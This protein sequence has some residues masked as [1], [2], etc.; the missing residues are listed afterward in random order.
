MKKLITIILT[1]FLFDRLYSQ[2]SPHDEEIMQIKG[3]W[4]RH[5]DVN[6]R[7]DSLSTRNQSGFAIKKIDSIA[8]LLK[9]ACPD[10]AGIEASWYGSIN[11]EPIF[12][13]APASYSLMSLYKS[14]YF[15]NNFNKILLG[16]ETGTWIYAD[17]N[18]LSRFLVD[19]GTWFIDGKP[20]ELFSL[21]EPDG[22]WKGWPVYKTEHWE[23]NTTMGRYKDRA[24]LLTR[25]GKLP[26]VPVTQKQYL[27][28]LEQRWSNAKKQAFEDY[29]KSEKVQQKNIEETRNNK[30]LSAEVK[31]KVIVDLQKQLDEYL[32]KRDMTI[33]KS[34]NYYD[35]KIKII[36]QYLSTHSEGEMQEPVTTTN[37][38]DFTGRFGADGKKTVYKLVR[39][40]PSYFDSH[41]PRYLP[42]LIILYWRCD[43]NTAAKEFIKQFEEKFPVE[44][45]K[46]MI[47]K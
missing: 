24:V 12:S 10:P 38:G 41:L 15:N 37:V 35:E 3:K 44:K 13:D 47:D 39:V 25:N 20:T 43:K 32:R 19:Q 40:D 21:L 2:P 42:Q 16:G 7:N 29:M 26:Y 14:Y 1:I 17:I 5:A 23:A 4:A 9:Q 8:Y 28:G 33:Q 30:Y 18:N 46:A 11:H 45:L 36:D 31:E 27:L 6:D 34:N 22:E